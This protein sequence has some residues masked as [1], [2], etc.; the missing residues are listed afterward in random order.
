MK[1]SRRSFIKYSSLALAGASILSNKIFAE[2]N[3]AGHFIGIQLY[4]VRDDMH[5]DPAATLKQIAAIGY[6]HVE[7]A[8]YAKRKFYDYSPA[9]FKKLLQDNG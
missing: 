1:T 2:E 6:T 8:G 5:K 3:V 9:D 4:T 7:H